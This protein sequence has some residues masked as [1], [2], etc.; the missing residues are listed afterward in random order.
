MNKLRKQYHIFHIVRIVAI[1]GISML[2][3]IS[4]FISIDMSRGA[5][6]GD[7]E[8]SVTLN[9]NETD[10]KIDYVVF[11]EAPDAN[12]GPPLDSYDEP[13]PPAP[14]PPYIRAW[15]ND[16]LSEPYNL[17]LKDYR[18]YPDTY[19]IWNLSIQWV[20]YDHTSTSVT[21]SW[22]VSEVDDSEYSIVILYDHEGNFL[23]NMTTQ[24]SYSFTCPATTPQNFQI[25]CNVDNEPPERPSK[26]SGETDGYHGTSYLYD[27]STNDSDGDNIFYFFNW[28]DG[29][30]SGWIG[31]YASGELCNTSHTWQIPGTYNI[32]VKAR[33]IYGNESDWS[34]QL[35]ITMG[36][37]APYVPSNPSPA[38]NSG[39][40]DINAALGWTGG[41]PDGDIITYDIY[42]GTETSPPKIISKQSSTSF[43]P[44]LIAKTTYH[45]KIVAW[46]NY[47]EST[48]GPVWSF[49][50]K[51]S[52][53]GGSSN[54]PPDEQENIPPAANASASETVGLVGSLLIFDGSQSLDQ[55]G[56]IK[57]WSW[58]FGDG[59]QD[60]GEMVTHAYVKSGTYNVTLT[61][62]DNLD[63][64][65]KD[66]I[67][68]FI[69]IANTPPSKP[70]ITGPTS[71]TKNTE[72]TYNATAT[73]ADND[74]IQY[75]FDW[76][77]GTTNTTAFLPNGTT[78]TQTHTWTA[79]GKY[80]ISVQVYDNQT[81]SD[82]TRHMVLIDAL[83]VDGIGYITDDDADG[84]YDTFHDTDQETDLGRDEDGKYLID[85]DGD[86]GWDYTYSQT[87][88][89]TTPF[90]EETIDEV[91]WAVIVLIATALAIIS[92]IVY[93]Y[94][95]GYF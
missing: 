77:D 89:I 14:M 62:T 81:P 82:I 12:D 54:G 43:T 92:L 26:P 5:P 68:V 36:N 74:T 45:W 31:P 75:H 25:I 13:K 6:I 4:A 60:N 57:N 51:E 32:S 59:N 40:V 48:P 18:R 55:D 56:Y 34:P 87:T 24:N 85:I 22:D 7:I 47:D 35:L 3:S 19:K 2:L 52:S 27:T 28:S 86:G 53:N 95:K 80:T 42:F 72:Y 66:S 65:D 63:A 29:T 23:K 71:G 64:T 30:N 50:T 78:V 20:P 44:S 33:D 58:D 61:V 11:G 17:L 67:T 37:R 84:T 93:F 90:T 1:F 94:K 38:N 73:D 41:D 15:F 79:A 8:W 16:N 83:I 39:G 49:T 9:F 70:T 10:G 69:G 76:D 21:M 91:P 88:G 46:D